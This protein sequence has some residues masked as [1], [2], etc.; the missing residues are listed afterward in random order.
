VDGYPS[1]GRNRADENACQSRQE[2]PDFGRCP[3]SDEAS[4]RE[5]LARLELTDLWGIAG[6]LTARLNAIGITTPFELHDA[7]HRLIRER[8]SVVLERMVLELRGLACID[9]EEV[10]PDRKSLIASQ[11]FGQGSKR[12]AASKRRSQS[13]EDTAGPTERSLPLFTR[14]ARHFFW[15]RT[16][17]IAKS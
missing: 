10:S 13:A 16:R 1:F 3:L 5:A 12:G 6:R 15:A 8:F 17:P 14:P 4:Q 9:L 11:S 2:R 7:D